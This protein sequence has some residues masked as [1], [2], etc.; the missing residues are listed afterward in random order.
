MVLPRLP[1]G[2][3]FRIVLQIISVI[4]SSLI[5]R[6][7][8]VPVHAVTDVASVLMALPVTTETSALWQ[9]T[10]A[11]KFAQVNPSVMTIIPA[12][13]IRAIPP[14]EN[15]LIP[16]FLQVH[17]VMMEVHAHM[18]MPVQKVSAWELNTVP[19]VPAVLRMDVT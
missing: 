18:M 16:H 7:S 3:L 12:L 17:P 2:V 1:D 19:R 15:V 8:A 6:V 5:V 14:R 13:L 9:T 11:V 4:L 10:A